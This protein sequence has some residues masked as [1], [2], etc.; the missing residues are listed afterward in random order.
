MILK[1]SLCLQSANNSLLTSVSL[2][3]NC[4]IK[5]Y[6]Y[7]K[8][9]LKFKSLDKRTMQLYK[10]YD[11]PV[12]GTFGKTNSRGYVVWFHSSMDTDFHRKRLV[13]LPVSAKRCIFAI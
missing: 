12:I 13:S 3:Y 9:I 2:P 10:F 6:K 8:Q 11:S 4:K 1:L 7:N 5:Q